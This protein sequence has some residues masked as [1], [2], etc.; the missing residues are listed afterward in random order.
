M[1][2]VM[3]KRAKLCENKVSNKDFVSKR[4]FC[5]IKERTNTLQGR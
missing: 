5:K 3:R 2:K 4:K 1:G